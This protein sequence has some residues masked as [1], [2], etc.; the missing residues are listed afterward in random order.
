MSNGA[1]SSVDGYGQR[2]CDSRASSFRCL[3]EAVPSAPA[4]PFEPTTP[5]E[6]KMVCG[7]LHLIWITELNR[8]AI[9]WSTLEAV[10]AEISRFER[11]LLSFPGDSE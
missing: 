1:N 7:R 2:S 8:E 5:V 6:V 11:A 9:N 3:A 10:A 4:L